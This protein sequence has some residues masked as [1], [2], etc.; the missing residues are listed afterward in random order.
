MG[1]KVKISQT[2]STILSLFLIGGCNITPPDNSTDEAMNLVFRRDNELWT[3]DVLGD[4]LKKIVPTGVII[5]VNE[6]GTEFTRIW[7]EG[8]QWSPDGKRIVF[9]EAVA[10]DIQNLKILDLESGKG[11]FFN[12]DITRND[13]TPSWNADGT[14]IFF[15]KVMHNPGWN[16]ELFKVDTSGQ[17]E[18]QI[19]SH[20]RYSDLYP[21]VN[22]LNDVIVYSA[23]DPLT[24]WQLYKMDI[25]GSNPTQLT[26]GI[27]QLHEMFTRPQFNPVNDD[28]VY[29]AASGD[30]SY[31]DIWLVH[32]LDFTNALQLTDTDSTDWAPS[33]SNDG[34]YIVFT[35]FE[36]PNR[37][38]HNPTVWIMNSDGT[39]QHKLI[40]NGSNPDIWITN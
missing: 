29:V 38:S 35:R 10:D 17:N 15:A 2:I 14:E 39:N 18:Q 3:Y 26:H 7:A 8:A 6:M 30:S 24:V 34:K 13:N 36:D 28:L 1:S 33:W 4:Q 22:R 25:D 21:T 23:Q 40:D 5:Y 20:P 31:K 32:D 11:K 16:Y 12:G 19:L 37:I 9:I 27:P